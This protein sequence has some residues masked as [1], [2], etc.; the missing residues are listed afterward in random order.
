[1]ARPQTHSRKE[2]IDASVE[3]VDKE[4]LEALTL[5]R[6]GTE[7]KVSYTAI[8]TYFKSRDDLLAALVERLSREIVDGIKVTGTSPRELVLAVG[9][10]ARRTLAKRPRLIPV[11]A[12]GGTD[13][14]DG[15][16]DAMLSIVTVLESAG[17]HGE[18]L[19]SAYRSIESYIIGATVFDY[20]AAPDHVK[21][22]R[23]RY[24]QSGHPEF[25]A[26]AKSDKSTIAHNEQAF[27]AGLERLLVAFGL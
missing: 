7:L 26:I 18:Q 9:I 13:G 12:M 11:F 6:L 16:A 15:A 4:G 2:F 14:S 3:I 27:V 8:Y 24:R 1:M 17:L 10:S 23:Q 22:R 5:R 25:V 19:T 21:L 20:G